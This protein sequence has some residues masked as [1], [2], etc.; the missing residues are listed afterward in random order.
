MILRGTSFLKWHKND[1]RGTCKITLRKIGTFS[2]EKKPNPLTFIKKRKK[3]KKK[4]TLYI[5]IYICICKPNPLTFIKIR[6]KKAIM[7]NG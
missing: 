4:Y 6:G 7:I 2:N 5:Y 1:T 3:E